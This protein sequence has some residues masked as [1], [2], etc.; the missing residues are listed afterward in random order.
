MARADLEYE[1]PPER[2]AQAPVQPRDAAR[3]LCMARDTGQLQERR[4]GD[5]PDL[6]DAR[7]L[8]VIN[9]TRVI[10]AKLRG[11]KASGGRAEALLIERRPDDSWIAFV[12]CGGRLRAGLA[13]RFG[14][15]EARVEAVSDD[16]VCRLRFPEAQIGDVDALLNEIGEAPLPP[17]IRRDEALSSDL[18]DYQS[19]FARTPGAVAAPTASLHFSEDLAARLRTASVTLHVGPGTFRPVRSERLEDHTLE[20]ERFEVPEATAQALRETRAAGGRVVAVGTTVVRALESTGGEP[21]SGRTGLFITP[22][23]EFRAVDSLITN[24]HLPGS[25]LLALVMAFGGVDAVRGA[26]AH[27]L[28]KNFRFYS[29]GDAMWIS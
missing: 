2:I 8:L 25:T 26:Y 23:H 19:V 27:A 1:L 7:D 16:G 17:Y 11:V 5:L 28:E 15:L 10:P 29:Y 22:G 14:E 18:N 9:D 20:P 21:G 12:R 6:L 4:F 24:F 3:M 13:L